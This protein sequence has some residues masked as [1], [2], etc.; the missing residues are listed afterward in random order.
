MPVFT[1]HL[2]VMDHAGEICNSVAMEIAYSYALH[3]VSD[4]D[5]TCIS[6]VR[7]QVNLE[8]W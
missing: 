8:Q 2:E 5:L 7:T 6:I 4:H 3:L 1:L